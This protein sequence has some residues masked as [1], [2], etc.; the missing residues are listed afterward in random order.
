M[1]NYFMIFIT[2]LFV[3][4]TNQ[5]SF[6]P[7]NRGIT[8]KNGKPYRVPYNTWLIVI[9]KIGTVE[10]NMGCHKG[11]LYWA[12][13]NTTKYISKFRTSR[14]RY[15]YLMQ[16]YKQGLAGCVKPLTNKEYQYYL[17]QQNQAAANARA[18]AYYKA[19]TAPQKVEVR[20]TG[21]DMKI[22]N[23]TMHY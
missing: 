23:M 2:V 18:A 10:K 16:A 17:N 19:A 14:E 15:P 5:P 8:F 12:Y 22:G 11:D 1:K 7:N 9:D 13:I 3:G 21:Y 4:C 20:Q 6:N